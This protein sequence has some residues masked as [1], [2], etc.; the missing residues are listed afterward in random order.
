[1]R[2]SW[3]STIDYSCYGL[4]LVNYN[5]FSP[6][7]NPKLET[8]TYPIPF[9]TYWVSDFPFPVWWDMYPFPS[10]FWSQPAHRRPNRCNRCLFTRMRRCKIRTFGR[11]RSGPATPA[12]FFEVEW[13]MFIYTNVTNILRKRTIVLG[14]L[15]GA[16]FIGNVTNIT[17]SED[18]SSSLR[19]FSSIQDF[20]RE[21]PQFR[22]GLRHLF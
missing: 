21:L 20:V 14:L 9:G 3:S 5:T 6:R 8:I 11:A 18:V 17:F 12:A 7:K 1:M 4:M 19:C 2:G 15:K 16:S 22:R 13:F 10:N